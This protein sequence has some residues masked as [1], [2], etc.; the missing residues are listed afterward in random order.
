MGLFDLLSR[1]GFSCKE[2]RSDNKKRSVVTLSEEWKESQKNVRYLVCD[3][4]N[5]IVFVDHDLDIDWGTTYELERSLEK[6]GI[7]IKT[8]HFNILAQA[9]VVETTPSD[10]LRYDSR[11]RFKRLVGEAIVCC[12][13]GQYE[14]AL[15]ILVSARQYL[16][17]RT[18]EV[19]RYWY[20]SSCLMF[21]VPYICVALGFWL[22]RTT[23]RPFLGAE[24]FWLVIAG[25]SGALGALL[26]VMSRTGNLAFNSSSG[27]GLHRLEAFSRISV[28][29]LS[30]GLVGLAIQ[31]KL[32]LS[33][34]SGGSHVVMMIAAFAAGAGER[35]A[36]SII[37]QFDR[38][39]DAPTVGRR[40]DADT[41]EQGMRRPPRTRPPRTRPPR[42]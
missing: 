23:L 21:S 12:F 20:L 27:L 35:L 1:V 28:G 3:D 9:A 19:S 41:P 8:K 32:F 42:S 16:R 2:R 15:N 36:P 37:A 18:Q 25:C 26:S 14:N 11:L 33:P 34:L 39:A 17:D 40:D 30:G 38:K 5:F 7:D 22:A 29:A 6:K 4:T 31:S 24:T 10:G 13:E